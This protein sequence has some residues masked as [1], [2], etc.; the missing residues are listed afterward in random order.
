MQ[1]YMRQIVIKSHVLLVICCLV[2]LSICDDNSSDIINDTG[3]RLFV[4]EPE[5]EKCHLKANDYIEIN[6][7]VYD[8]CRVSESISMKLTD[9]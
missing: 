6:Q 8:P 7:Q 5:T 4:V 9:E 1:I 3:K 2:A